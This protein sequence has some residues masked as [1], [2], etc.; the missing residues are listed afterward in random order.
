MNSKF[1]IS[2]QKLSKKVMSHSRLIQKVFFVNLCYLPATVKLVTG[3][4][5][6]G[7]GT[8]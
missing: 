3:N 2:T 1:E 7:F 6:D 8:Q 5:V 4:I